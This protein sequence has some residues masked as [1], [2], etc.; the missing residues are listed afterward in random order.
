[1]HS[2]DIEPSRFG[3][4]RNPS[5]PPGKPS[6]RCDSR[7][8][9]HRIVGFPLG[10]LTFRRKMAVWTR[11]SSKSALCRPWLAVKTEQ[12]RD[13]CTRK[14]KTGASG[15]QR[16]VLR[17]KNTSGRVPNENHRFG[18]DRLEEREMPHNDEFEHLKNRPIPNL[19]EKTAVKRTVP[20]CSDWS[21]LC[22]GNSVWGRN[23]VLPKEN[24]CFLDSQVWFASVL[25]PHMGTVTMR[26][27]NRSP[28]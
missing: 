23:V 6:K 20:C 8:L 24:W 7:C 27:P 19:N 2:Q 22:L 5:N 14:M 3:N 4:P 21:Q 16:V 18:Q 25:G 17:A 28:R 1:M 26:P 15:S 9:S 11:R 10:K 12:V 13:G